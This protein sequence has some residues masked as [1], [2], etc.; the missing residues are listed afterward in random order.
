MSIISETPS[1]AIRVLRRHSAMADVFKIFDK[2]REGK[3]ATDLIIPLMHCLGRECDDKELQ[4]IVSTYD[5]SKSGWLTYENFISYMDSTFTVPEEVVKEVVDS[6]R[7]FD[8]NGNGLI[9]YEEFRHILMDFGGDFKEKEVRKI[10]DFT[11]TDSD[12]VISYAE[13]VQLWKYQ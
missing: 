2:R 9:N 7:V 1:T 11:D 6:F 4:Y 3:I 5:K 10:F 13:F 12:G 8:V